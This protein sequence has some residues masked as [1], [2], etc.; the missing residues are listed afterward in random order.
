MNTMKLLAAR[1]G[2]EDSFLDAHGIER[3]TSPETR[4]ALLAAMGV[5]AD[6]EEAAVAA[7]D[8][9]DRSEWLRALPPVHVIQKTLPLIVP[10]TY[11]P[12]TDSVLWRLTLEDGSHKTGQAVF[13]S[14]ALLGR[15]ELDGQLR[16]QRALELDGV[17]IP[18]GYH[19]LTVSP[20]D[21]VST[22]IITPGQCWL[23][24]AVEQGGRL[25]GVAA[26]LY[27]LKS[28]AN[29]GIGD[30]SDLR[31]LA[32]ICARSGAQVIGLNPLHAMFLDDP[33]HASPY[34]PA[35]RYLLNVLNIDVMNVAQAPPCVEALA[36]IRAQSFQV[37]LSACR[38]SDRV[39][40]TQVARLK[41]SVLE[42][43]FKYWCTIRESSYWHEFEAFRRGADQ[44]FERSC[45]FLA[46]RDHFAAQTPALP[47]WH[48]WPKE[49]QSPDTAA[50]MQFAEERQERVTFQAWLQY[51]ADKQL[52]E[53]AFA[54]SPM[55]I[56]LYR[57]LAVG[58]DPSGA[59]TWA[60][61]R[62]VVSLAQVGAPP[63][64]YNP[65]GQR[66][67]LPPFHPMV[68]KNEGYRSFIELLRAN[69]RHAGGLRIDHVMALQQLYWVP[70]GSTAAQ[71]AYVRYPMEDLIGILALESHRNR[72]LVVGEDLGTVPPGFRERMMR[73]RILSY[74]VL[75]FEKDENGFVPPQS[76][77]GLSLAVA[78]S[79]DLPTIGAWM[80]ASD[81][82]LKEKLDLFPSVKHRDAA[83]LDRAYD[84]RE[85]L[86]AFKEGGLG[87]NPD[88]PLNEFSG[89][90]HAFLARTAS[91]IAMVQ[92]DDI[93]QETRPVNVP[94]TSNEYPNWR[95]RLS[96]NLENIPGDAHFLALTRLMN[97]IRAADH[98]AQVRSATRATSAKTWTGTYRLQLHEDFPLDAASKILPYLKALGISHVYLS[99]CLQASP[100]SR[101]GYDVTNAT[102]ISRD[103][104]GE[105]GWSRFVDAARA[106]GLGILLDIVPNHMAATAKNE[107]WDDVLAHGPYSPYAQFFDIRISDGAPF[108]L[109]LCSLGRPYGEALQSG[110]LKLTLVDGRPRFEH[111]DNSWPLAA[112]SWGELVNPPLEASNLT[113]D[114]RLDCFKEL[115]DLQAVASPSADDREAYRRCQRDA[116]S[117]L[118]DAKRA[119]VLEKAIARVNENAARL[120]A[121]LTRQFFA[122][123]SWMLSGE[124][125]NYRRFFEV[126]S[127]V[128]IRTELASVFEATHA[129]IS[130]MLSRAE[131]DGLRVDHPDGLADPKAYFRQLRALLPGGRIYVEK[132]LG[133]DERLEQTW[134]VDGTVGYDFLAKVNR[135]WMDD[136]HTDA[137]TSIYNDFTGHSVNAGALV[138]QKQ[139][140]VLDSA[141]FGELSRLT[142]M[143]VHIARRDPDTSDLSPRY[144]RE[145][146]AAV[147]AG[148][149]I[150]RTY[151]T[152]AAIN[153]RDTRIL[154]ETLQA[155]RLS[156]PQ[157]D[158]SIF[159]F[160]ESLLCK[161]RL[162]EFEAEFVKQWQQLTPAVMAK[163]VEDTTFY[164][165]D[166]LLSCNE[167][168]ASAS[169]LGISSEKFHEYCHY[170]SEHWPHNLLATSTHDNKRSEDVR[171][172]I[173]L[174]SEIPE[175]WAQILHQWSQINAEAWRNRNPDRHAEY[176]LYQTMIGAWPIDQERCWQYM[177][178]A[179]R[180]AKINTS[181]HKPNVAYEEKI[182]VF[183]ENVLRNA[184]FISSIESFIAP[185]I[186]P[187]RINSLAQTLLKLVAPGV[188]DFYQG[189]E[190]WDL[191]L[192]DPDNRRPVDYDI[193]ARLLAA[194]REMSAEAVLQDWHSGLPKIWMV[195]RVLN[196]RA[197][198]PHVFCGDSKYQPL[199]ASGTRLSNLISCRRG[200]NV[201]AVVPRFGMTVDGDWQDTQLP[202]PTGEWRNLFGGKP[203]RTSAA[204]A[205]LFR[206]FPVALLVRSDASSP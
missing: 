54:A 158:P 194:C 2:I 177:L 116:L 1:Y 89:A 45:L 78:G 83:Q 52:G 34:S 66:W 4:Q 51:L 25:W 92:M 97:E 64:I 107:W 197:Q 181:W 101:H 149:P 28:K 77:P 144:L 166:R 150:Y 110:E 24:P 188:P 30:F 183:T 148:L 160:L 81:L 26:Q 129:R 139:Q 113:A 63:D 21:A 5:N 47:D 37:A 90:V 22:L 68:L 163:G 198:N 11:D 61:P 56:G 131:L 190:L 8:E 40:Y 179:L 53:A 124:L 17:D 42:V 119:G 143:L 80:T 169:M 137:L 186:L 171:T 10:V 145:A 111:F 152:G 75:F 87:D 204:A 105:E 50:V 27:L 196:Y 73:A 46:L 19:R 203:L 48:T 39:D 142:Q 71:G 60:N 31:Q 154:R 14:L 121:M 161:S 153:V 147:T 100:G 182:R 174:L 106:Q 199:A 191:S 170:L 41:L 55:A 72:C 38:D 15:R 126:D 76:Y 108:R 133:N 93:T 193:R 205:L 85:L 122:L 165:F 74:R 155:V 159:V 16:E 84:R 62:A 167:V 59:E 114:R 20:G 65:A 23:P 138:R 120:H 94:T 96:M 102:K 173:S 67:G 88:M 146:L 117:L 98:S 178:K 180:E 192:V 202:L 7:L 70:A 104:G 123:H 127:L 125:T 184:E 103:L 185:L 157:I 3:A 86:A 95:R 69:M 118:E 29:W 115:I 141:F 49:Y 32:Q 134:H 176:L 18:M 36:Q 6:S 130:T 44:T 200:D 195:S 58:A 162:T 99:P 57:D 206:D 172:R 140:E 175:R 91:A 79:H 43:I 109:E 164:V 201:I 12:Q 136:S 33:E 9:V 187:G 135:L 35:S 156:S 151:R 13:S 168:G 132:I 128:G 82:A 189:S 112:A